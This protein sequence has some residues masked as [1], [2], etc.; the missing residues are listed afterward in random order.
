MKRIVCIIL[1]IIICQDIIFAQI[2]Q[3]AIGYS[4]LENGYIVPGEI[5]DGDSVIH[6]VLREITVRPPYQFKSRK[7]QERYSRLVQYVRRVYPYSKLIKRKF[8][9]IQVTLDSIPDEKQKK[10]FIKK[11]EKELRD[12]FE[13]E[14]VKLTITQ[15]RI[16]I[17]LVDRETGETT[18]NVVKQ[19][20]GSFSAFL[21]QSV[22][23]LF[24]SNLK[25]EYQAEGDDK[26]IEDIIVRIENGQL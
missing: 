2:T 7:E 22:A 24:G 3:S 6:I 10:V 26:M 11:K 19:L 9:E 5:V 23:L 4:V 12:E 18:Y 25:A 13:G 17:K 8:F 14:L 20:K 16:L 15:G 21:W 1:W